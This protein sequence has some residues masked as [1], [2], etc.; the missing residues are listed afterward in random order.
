MTII[1][2]LWIAILSISTIADPFWRING[3][4]QSQTVSGQQILGEISSE[5]NFGIALDLGYHIQLYDEVNLI[6]ALDR[7]EKIKGQ[8]IL[9]HNQLWEIFEQKQYITKDKQQLD[10]LLI[11]R[12]GKF[13]NQW[14]VKQLVRFKKKL[15]SSKELLVSARIMKDNNEYKKLKLKLNKMRNN[16]ILS[17]DQMIKSDILIAPKNRFYLQP[18]ATLGFL[19]DNTTSAQ[20]VQSG[21]TT[22]LITMN[23][24]FS[25]TFEVGRNFDRLESDF[26]IFVGISQYS[27]MV[28]EQYAS[29]NQDIANSGTDL[30]FIWGLSYRGII[31][32][33]SAIGGRVSF[34]N[35]SIN[36]LKNQARYWN[37]KTTGLTFYY[38]RSF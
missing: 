31:D 19:S 21:S 36:A 22:D 14:R 11:F 33:Y 27:F 17:D 24:P 10:T 30:N 28:S 16:I 34:N 35:A 4:V 25:L 15:W 2:L 8:K 29:D 5:N 32:Q 13:R 18:L 23:Q 3:V 37:V 7:Q 1:K 26:G 9:K 12:K 20:Y 6:Q 38:K